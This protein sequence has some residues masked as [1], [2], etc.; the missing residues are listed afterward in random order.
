MGLF[1]TVLIPCPRC[2]T[3]YE[4]QTKAGDC[5]LATYRLA[6]APPE[7]KADIANRTLLCG[8]GMLFYVVVQCI[9]MVVP[10]RIDDV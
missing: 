5:E 7:L 8:C 1:D 3:E 4:E 9:A 6:E 10:G 2:G